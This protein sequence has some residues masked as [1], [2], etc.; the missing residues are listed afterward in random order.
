[1]RHLGFLVSTTIWAVFTAAPPAGAV[2]LIDIANSVRGR[3]CGTLP[4]VGR[5]LR[6][7]AQL[8]DAARRLAKGD[9]LETAT[10]EAGYR[11]RKSASIRIH[12][13]DGSGD[14]AQLLA[15]RFCDIVA[16]ESLL[17]AGAFRRGDET[18]MV[19]ATPLAP[20]EHEDV[21]TATRRVL[22]LVNQARSQVRRCGRKK[23][24]GATPLRRVAALEQAA[25][26]HAQDMA[27]Q[28]LLGHEGSDGST[29]ARRATQAGYSW[30]SVAENVAG[31]QTTADEV[32]GTWIASSGH[33]A[34][35]MNPRYSET[36][37]ARGIDPNSEHVIYWVQVFAAPD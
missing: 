15:Q 6:T 34:N 2:D 11:A 37:I 35:L 30:D 18:W 22:E 7:Q 26:L 3:G 16:D 12:T 27:A 23:F 28:S 31:G 17:E 36:G 33:C 1:M 24:N 5:A 8:E 19:L 4:A 13:N 21:A 25:Q 10:S 14:V 32:V 20:P 9:D 29:P